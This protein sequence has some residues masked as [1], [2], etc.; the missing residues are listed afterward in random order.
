M[1][2]HSALFLLQRY[3]FTYIDVNVA[4]L[5]CLAH[6]LALLWGIALAVLCTIYTDLDRE[7]C[8]LFEHHFLN[9]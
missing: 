1:Q 9:K 3:V 8:C 4:L 7:R 6:Y 2:W 5:G